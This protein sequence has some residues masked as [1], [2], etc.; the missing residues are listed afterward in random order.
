MI[1][2]KAK[3]NN[4]PRVMKW[5]LIVTVFTGLL[6]V[7]ASGRFPSAVA[8]PTVHAPNNGGGECSVA[9]LEGTYGF[10]RTG[11]NNIL[12]GPIAALGLVAF[13]GGGTATG[14]LETVSRNGE[15]TRWTLIPP[16][17][18]VVNANCTGSFLDDQGIATDDFVIVNEGKEFLLI[19]TRSGRIVTAIGK[20]L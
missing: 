4:M 20:K 5:T 1:E 16:G 11:T 8:A 15:I 14:G 3:E 2:L 12:G 19:S 6:V 17:P 7:G 9:T 18:Y 13:D 10:L